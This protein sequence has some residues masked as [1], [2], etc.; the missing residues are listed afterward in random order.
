V[1]LFEHFTFPA[2]PQHLFVFQHLLFNLSVT[3]PCMMTPPL[4]APPQAT[5][6]SKFSTGIVVLLWLGNFLLTP[7]VGLIMW[8]VLRESHPMK[9]KQAGLPAL[10]AFGAF[11]VLFVLGVMASLFLPSFLS[12]RSR[13]NEMDIQKY[14][15]AVVKSAYA[16]QAETG[17][18][19]LDQDCTDGY[20]A[21]QYLVEAPESSVKNAILTCA[22]SDDRGTPKVTVTTQDGQTFSY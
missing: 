2:V 22:L 4:P 8:A 5:D 7:L 21:G 12:A 1:W 3:L 6:Q 11:L 18:I 20:E 14:A 19:K 17:E 16:Y 10:V 15:Q 13:A 9:A